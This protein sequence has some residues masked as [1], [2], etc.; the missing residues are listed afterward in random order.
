MARV[1]VEKLLERLFGV[2]GLRVSGAR[3]EPRG[4]VGGEAT[5]AQVPLWCQWSP[6][7]ALRLL[8]AA[9]VASPGTGTNRFLVE[10]RPAP[11]GVPR[12]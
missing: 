3:F 11:G 9:T 10:L 8:S 4:V 5:P 12:A 6:L 7:P 1:G 2:K